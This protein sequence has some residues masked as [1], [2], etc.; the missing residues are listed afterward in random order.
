VKDGRCIAASSS[1]CAASTV[2]A[3]VKLCLAREGVC[4]GSGIKSGPGGGSAAPDPNRK[5]T[6]TSPLGR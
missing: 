6:I 3:Q 5:T 1:D 2:C 4:V